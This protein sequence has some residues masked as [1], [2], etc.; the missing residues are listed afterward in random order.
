MFV[1]NYP[2]NRRGARKIVIGRVPGTGLR[3]RSKDERIKIYV[4][5]KVGTTR[6]RPVPVFDDSKFSG[7]RS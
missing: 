7:D 2:D 6:K 1:M 5:D 4:V 3:D